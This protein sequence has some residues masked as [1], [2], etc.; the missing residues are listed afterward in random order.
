[1]GAIGTH[2]VADIEGIAVLSRKTLTGSFRR[3]FRPE[4]F[5]MN[6]HDNHLSL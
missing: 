4:P 6:F 1:M 5:A 2:L 3:A